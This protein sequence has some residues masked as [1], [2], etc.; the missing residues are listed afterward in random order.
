MFELLQIGTW[1]FWVAILVVSCFI[2]AAESANR[3][4]N[5][6]L[7]VVVFTLMFGSPLLKVLRS[8][9]ATQIFIFLG[10]YIAAG[11]I[12][13]LFKWWLHCKRV[14]EEIADFTGATTITS[15]QLQRLRD[16]LTVSQNKSRL[17]FYIAFWPWSMAWSGLH[18]FFEGMYNRLRAKYESIAKAGLDELTALETKKAE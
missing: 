18:D 9:T 5:A 11:G 4:G 14:R 12:W 2:F 1:F 10:A 6:I 13:S 8:F 16:K 17:T 15:F 7:A 3:K